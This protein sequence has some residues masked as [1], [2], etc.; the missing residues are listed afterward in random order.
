[1]A[2][3]LGGFLGVQAGHRFVQQHQPGVA[4]EAEEVGDR[5]VLLGVGGDLGDPVAL[6]VAVGELD[7]LSA[8]GGVTPSSIAPNI[9][10][11]EHRASGQRVDER[12][13]ACPRRTKQ[14]ER[15]AGAE[16]VAQ[17]DHTVA[18]TG[19]HAE[20]V[21]PEGHRGGPVVS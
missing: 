5:Q 8:R 15:P 12:A 16:V 19:T 13:L 1:M 4:V 6:Q 21:R 17:R 3:D 2:G 10:R 9:G 11:L 14:H 7:Q 18:G 20:H